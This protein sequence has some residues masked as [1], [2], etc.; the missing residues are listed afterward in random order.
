M[1]RYV[2]MPVEVGPYAGIV[3]E[4]FANGDFEVALNGGGLIN[5][6][7]DGRT[8]TEIEMLPVVRMTRV[9]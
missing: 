2:G 1:S 4:I 3:F 6:S 9:A 5:V 7:E 8:V